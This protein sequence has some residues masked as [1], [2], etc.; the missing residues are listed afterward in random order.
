MFL[1]FPPKLC[2]SS[3]CSCESH[4]HLATTRCLPSTLGSSSSVAGFCTLQFSRSETNERLFCVPREVMTGSGKSQQKQFYEAGWSQPCGLWFRLICTQITRDGI[5]ELR[6]KKGDTFFS[7]CFLACGSPLPVT[8][9]N[10]GL[11]EDVHSW[12]F[13]STGSFQNI[14]R[15]FIPHC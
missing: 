8:V 15:A 5:P 11:L 2:N 14:R 13:R 1:P 12:I 4:T 3:Q 10:A 7:F 9:S 6:C